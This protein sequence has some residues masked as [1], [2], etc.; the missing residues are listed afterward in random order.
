MFETNYLIGRLFPRKMLCLKRCLYLPPSTT[1]KVLWIMLI[2][3]VGSSPC[4]TIFSRNA[5]N[6]S[7]VVIPVP[8]KRLGSKLSKSDF[9]VALRG[10]KHATHV[11]LVVV[12]GCVVDCRC[13]SI[14]GLTFLFYSSSSSYIISRS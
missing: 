11:S 6:Y 13:T 1:S 7:I 3:S 10:L 2:A 8:A 12:G 5:H 9:S 4:P 14:V